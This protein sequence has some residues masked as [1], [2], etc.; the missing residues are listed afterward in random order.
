MLPVPSGYRACTAC[1]GYQ[2]MSKRYALTIVP[3]PVQ[4]DRRAV[5]SSNFLTAIIISPPSIR[6]FDLAVK[7]LRKDVHLIKLLDF[8]FFNTSNITEK[9]SREIYLGGEGN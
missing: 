1:S 2:A 8:M 3:R 6:L 4:T 5:K 7:T 9:K